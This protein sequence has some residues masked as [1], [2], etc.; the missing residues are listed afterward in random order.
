MTVLYIL[1]LI[2]IGLV[3]GFWFH[4][5]SKQPFWR[6]PHWKRWTEENNFD[7][8]DGWGPGGRG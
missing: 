7:W 8:H 6:H 2:L 5:Y 1:M 4:W 3:L